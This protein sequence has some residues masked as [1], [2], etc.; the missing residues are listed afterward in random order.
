MNKREP[1]IITGKHRSGTSLL[2]KILI[3][4]GIFMGSKLDSN[5]ESIFFQR[6]INQE[7]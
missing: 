1:I 5:S 3:D 2:S 6:K 4:Q 7:K